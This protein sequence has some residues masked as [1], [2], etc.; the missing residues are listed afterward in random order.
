MACLDLNGSKLIYVTENI[1]I[2][3]VERILNTAPISKTLNQEH[4]KG[5]SCV[6][7][8][9]WRMKMI[10]NQMC[11]LRQYYGAHDT[12]AIIWEENLN[13]LKI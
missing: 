11:S 10:H 3:F 13:N 2:K 8:F 7:L 6:Q 12:T 5:Q 9:S 4:L 1:K